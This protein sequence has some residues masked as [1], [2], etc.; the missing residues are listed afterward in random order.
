[1][2][3]LLRG[4]RINLPCYAG[5]ASCQIA[6]DGEVWA[7]CIKSESLGNLRNSNY[8]FRKIWFSEEAGAL[9]TAIKARACS[10][11]LANAAY[12]NMLFSLRT[13]IG[14]GREVVLGR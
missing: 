12:T 5:V 11:P 3:G 9:R 13:L 10:C 1:V 2:E 7:C 8:D 6:P 4:D 14:I